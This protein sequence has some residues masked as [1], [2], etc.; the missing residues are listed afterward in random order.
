[1]LLQKTPNVGRLA[2][3]FIVPFL[4]AC[5]SDEAETSNTVENVSS[6]RPVA[7]TRVSN[8]AQVSPAV[9]PTREQRVTDA[10]VQSV[11]DT[12]FRSSTRAEPVAALNTRSTVYFDFDKSDI[13]PEALVALDRI[14]ARVKEDLTTQVQIEGHCDARG[15]REYNLALGERRGSA[16]AG[17]LVSRG[18]ANYRIKVVSRGEEQLAALGNNERAHAQN[19]R[20]AITVK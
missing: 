4:V 16:V 20:A 2:V 15:T 1:M 6:E 10:D 17:Y 8:T 12:G 9:A 11:S 5:G 14:V 19:R 18:V 3:L 7:D 13:K